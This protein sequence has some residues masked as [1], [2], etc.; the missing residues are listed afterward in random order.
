MRRLFA[1]VL[2]LFLAGCDAYGDETSGLPAGSPTFDTA[3]AYIETDGNTA[4]FNVEVADT[5]E[6]RAYGLMNRE[7]LPEDSGMLFVFF[8]PSSGGFW[9]KDTPVPLSIAFFDEDGEIISMY[10]MDPCTKEPCK[11]YRPERRY[12]GALE[13]NQGAFEEHG[14]EVGDVVRT[15]Q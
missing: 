11:S 10:D 13:V 1:L 2:L 5:P 12:W 4:L 14:V 8:E 15:N 3:T 7:S 9:M 6:E